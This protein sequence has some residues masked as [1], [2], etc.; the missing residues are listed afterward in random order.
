[1]DGIV[2]AI[3]GGM[4]SY[5]CGNTFGLIGKELFGGSSAMAV[6]GRQIPV[7]LGKSSKELIY[8]GPDSRGL[9]PLMSC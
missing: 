4:G 8:E 1:M 9:Q 2:K 5:I 6:F 7:G 3:Y